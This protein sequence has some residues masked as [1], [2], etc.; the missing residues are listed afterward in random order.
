MVNVTLIDRMGE[1][2]KVSCMVSVLK[3]SWQQ[4][5]HILLPID[6][7][8][9]IAEVALETDSCAVHSNV[10]CVNEVISVFL[11]V[12]LAVRT[13]LGIRNLIRELVVRKLSYL[14]LLL[15]IWLWKG[16]GFNLKLSLWLLTASNILMMLLAILLLVTLVLWRGNWFLF[17]LDTTTTTIQRL[18]V[19]ALDTFIIFGG[20]LMMMMVSNTILSAFFNI[21][22]EGKSMFIFWAP[23]IVINFDF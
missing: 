7:D 14:R 6:E 18:L 11:L 9:C 19:F 4:L 16:R 8:E 2:T 10:F 5:R 23:M 15:F 12:W 3:I 21:L 17:R 1:W 22:L 13:V 20:L